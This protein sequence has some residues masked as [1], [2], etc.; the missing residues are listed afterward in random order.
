VELTPRG[1]VIHPR[2]GKAALPRIP[3]GKAIAGDPRETIAAWL[4]AADNPY[5]ARAAV[6]RLWREVMGRGLVEPV[7]DHRVTNPPTHPRL[8]DDLARDFVKHGFDVKHTLRLIVNSAAYQRSSL[9]ND[10]NKGDDRFYSKAL[11]RPLPPQVLVDAVARV[12]GVPEK[13][14]ALPLGTRAITL[15]DAKVMSQP[16]DLLGRCAR[17]NDCVDGANG[18][19]LPLALHTMGDERVRA[20]E[21]FLWGLLNSA[22][23]RSNH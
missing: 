7:D 19:G 13:L 22:E 21:D 14:G 18:G 12:T 15:G 17:V 3:A 6:N 8:L 23:F 5:F 20:F 2:T 1:E 4:T 11:V 10:T 9:A 16:L